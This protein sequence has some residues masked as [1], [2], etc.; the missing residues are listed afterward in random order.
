[1]EMDQHMGKGIYG[2]RI[3]EPLG[4]GAYAK[5]YRALHVSTKTP[6]AVK[7]NFNESVQQGSFVSH[8]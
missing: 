4:E 2:Y 5:V 7:G 6:V 3:Q 1:M 8:P